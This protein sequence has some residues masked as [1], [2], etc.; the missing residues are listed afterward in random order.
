MK[1]SMQ[2]MMGIVAAV[3]LTAGQASALELT[4]DGGF[5]T[6]DLSGWSAFDPAKFTL[7]TTTP[8][9]GSFSGQLTQSTAPGSALAKQANKGIGIVTPGMDITVSFW[10]RGSAAFGGVHFAEL[11]SELDGGGVSK[12]ELLGGAPLLPASSTDWQFYSF[13]TTL[14]AD[15]SGGVTLQFVAVTGAD[16]GSTSVLEIDDVSLSVVPEP[17]SLALLGLGGLAMLG[18]RARKA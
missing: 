4:D 14:G 18:R 17:A 9:A 10:A 15:V 6:G 7:N 5:E 1:K 11:F 8:H 2:M 12:S 16:A 3:L 13:D